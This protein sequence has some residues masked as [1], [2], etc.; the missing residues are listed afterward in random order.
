MQ[1]PH[2]AGAITGHG[3]GNFKILKAGEH[4]PLHTILHPDFI[5][6]PSSH[7]LQFL[8]PTEDLYGRKRKQRKQDTKQ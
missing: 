6:L 8:T 4:L 2:F 3:R 5:L 7:T 1:K